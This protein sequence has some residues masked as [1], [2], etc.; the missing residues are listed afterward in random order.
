MRDPNRIKD[1]CD[2]LA[3]I[4]GLVPD[5]RLSQLMMNAIHSYTEEKGHD[6]FYTEDEEFLGYLFN[7]AVK[8]TEK[9]NQTTKYKKFSDGWF[10][11][12]VNVET[13][14]KKWELESGDI[15]V[16]E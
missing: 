4:W 7:Y 1:Y 2:G 10:T 16:T 11:Y 15:E 12:Y 8:V 6:P 13:G 9:G 5:W 14:E 3:T